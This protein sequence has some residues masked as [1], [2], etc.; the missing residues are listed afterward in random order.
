MHHFLWWSFWKKTHLDIPILLHCSKE[1]LSSFIVSVYMDCQVT[2][3]AVYVTAP[4]VIKSSNGGFSW[5]PFALLL[6]F[7]DQ[8]QWCVEKCLTTGFG[9]QE[10]T[11][12]L[13][14]CDHTW[15][16]PWLISSYQCDTTKCGV[17]KRWADQLSGASVSHLQHTTGQVNVLVRSTQPEL[18]GWKCCRAINCYFMWSVL[19]QTVA[20]S[21]QRTNTVLM[22]KQEWEWKGNTENE[23]W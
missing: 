12:D 11:T 10:G 19:S 14:R 1:L 8:R 20:N 4:P 15:L 23:K 9:G 2:E 7:I 21:I 3:V 16:V 6:S 13:W 22:Y 17:G 18:V 5:F